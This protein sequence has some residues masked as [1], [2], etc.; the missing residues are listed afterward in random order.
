MY[1]NFDYVIEES[2]FLL[3]DNLND[4]EWQALVEFGRGQLDGT[5]ERISLEEWLYRYTHYGDIPE[6]GEEGEAEAVK[7]L[8][9][10]T[11]LINDFWNEVRLHG[12]VEYLKKNKYER[13]HEPS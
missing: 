12:I 2:K 7:E 4:Q 10:M 9:E 3:N 8:K 13:T 5:A 11:L 1:D 6:G